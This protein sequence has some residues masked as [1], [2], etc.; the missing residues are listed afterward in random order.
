MNNYR[1]AP[2]KDGE[3]RS[4]ARM[5]DGKELDVVKMPT[6]TNVGP[7]YEAR[8]WKEN[9][10]TKDDAVTKERGL[11]NLEEAKDCSFK[12]WKISNGEK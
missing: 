4:V 9:A 10:K 11:R 6:I 7:T 2:W 5:P 1:D 12:M 8:V 3:T